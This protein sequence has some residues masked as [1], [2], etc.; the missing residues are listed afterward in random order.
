MLLLDE[1]EVELQVVNKELQRAEQNDDMKKYRQLLT[2]QKKLKKED[3]KLRYNLSSKMGKDYIT[4]SSVMGKGGD[5][6]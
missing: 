4:K 1:I 6:D 3:F 5:E 2:Y